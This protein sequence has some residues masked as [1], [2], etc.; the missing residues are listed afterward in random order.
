MF[1]AGRI[2][3]GGLCARCSAELA[4]EYQSPHPKEDD[5]KSLGDRLK[6]CEAALLALDPSTQSHYWRHWEAGGAAA[7]QALSQTIS[8]NMTVR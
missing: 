1:N 5:L 8:P 2:S 7:Q 4:G 3:W 6:D